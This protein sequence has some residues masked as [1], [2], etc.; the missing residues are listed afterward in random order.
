MLITTVPR[1]L[2]R[3]LMLLS[4]ILCVCLSTPGLRGQAAS[5]ARPLI[6]GPIDESVR[7]T[8][9]DGVRPQTRQDIDVG[10]LGGDVPLDRIILLLKRSQAAQ[11][12]F[13]QLQQEQQDPKSPLFH[14]W[15]TPA[16]IGR[17]FGAAPA[18]RTLLLNWLQ[19]YGF[20]ID[21]FAK[22]GL[23]VVFSGSEAQL[24]AAFDTSMHSYRSIAGDLHVANSREPSIPAALAPPGPP[25]SQA[26]TNYPVKPL[27]RIY[28]AAHL[29]RGADH[30]AWSVQPGVPAELTGKAS[31]GAAPANP[32]NPEFSASVGPHPFQLV[33]PYDFAAIYN[34]APLWNAGIDGT[35]ET[36]A[37]LAVSD[38]NPGDVDSFRAAFGLPAKP[39]NMVYYGPNP[40]LGAAE[41]EADLDA[42][43]SGAVAKNAGHRRRG[44]AGYAN[45]PAA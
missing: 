14:Q 24:E 35:G 17:Q 36:V 1:P 26:S 10:V 4:T 29:N 16:Q 7:V 22:S 11:A 6:Q 13:D 2:R 28:G 32:I 34:V 42:E 41:G 27:S 31:A 37:V 8:L 12:A 3:T 9:K 19:G 44:G 45:P 40:G 5:S 39:V 15:L 18:D 38:I 30:A 25:A 33:S 23:M 43:W 20:H 21:S